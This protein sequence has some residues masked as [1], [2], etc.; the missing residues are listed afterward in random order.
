MKSRIVKNQPYGKYADTFQKEYAKETRNG[1]LV[2]NWV[3]APFY[4]GDFIFPYWDGVK[5]IE[6]ATPAEIQMHAIQIGKDSIQKA[7]KVHRSTGKQ[8]AQDFEDYLAEYVLIYQQL[9]EDQ[10][11]N[12]GRFLYNPL[13]IV[14][15]GQWKSSIKD[16]NTLVVSE[17]YMQPFVTKLKTDIEKYITDNYT[18]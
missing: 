8:Y 11:L 13:L 9:T 6:N 5:Y 3:M 16:L 2:A 14:A 15:R 4:D 10:A 7:Y 12:I 18:A 17:A 1:Q